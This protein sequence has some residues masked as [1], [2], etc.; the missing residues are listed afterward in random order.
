MSEQPFTV[1]PEPTDLRIVRVA[2][3]RWAVAGHVA[4]DDYFRGACSMG[5]LEMDLYGLDLALWAEQAAVEGRETI[6]VADDG[7]ARAGIPVEEP[8]TAALVLVADAAGWVP[9]AA[10]WDQV[11]DWSSDGTRPRL[12]RRPAARGFSEVPA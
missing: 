4:E 8:W 5:N 3:D 10:L 9:A 12:E 1:G 11:G 6:T 2:E 7:T